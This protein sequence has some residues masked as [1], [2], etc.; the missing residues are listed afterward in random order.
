MLT[1]LVRRLLI[2]VLTLWA[3]TL[4][5]YALIR[6]MPGEPLSLNL[7]GGQKINQADLERI[8]ES[9]GLNDAWHVGY[10]K[11]LKLAVTGE[12][13]NSISK[14][15]PV[16]EVVGERIGVTLRLSLTSLVL[17]YLLSIPLGLYCSARS[18]HWDE[19]TIS[20]LLY[21]LYSLPS[22]VAAVLLQS[23]FSVKMQ[24][25]WLEL[26]L[27]GIVSDQHAELSP[28]GQV[29]DLFV[30]MILPVFCYTY[31]A[32]AYEARFIRANMAEVVRQD[33]IRTARAKGASETSVYVRHAFRNTLI[34]LVTLLGLTF[35][36]LL[37][38]AVILE[39]IFSLPGMGGLLIESIY[40]RDYPV[41]MALVLLFS[42]MTL[43]GQLLADLLY[44]AV[45]PRVAYE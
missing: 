31:A 27:T 16:T 45:D 4:L 43:I 10:L 17:A 26:P 29:W 3:V 24:G 25:T 33:Y 5:T 41:I 38:G 21:M 30:H 23:Y 2:A 6:N 32:L 14:K 37:S 1:Y 12:L 15:K 7:E 22:F 42:L 36:T 39:Q 19:S 35:P 40:S 9:Y 20:T 18:G 8:R 28:A 13:G 34:P 11:W 44:A